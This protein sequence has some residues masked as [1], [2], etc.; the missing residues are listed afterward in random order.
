MTSQGGPSW[1][2][3]LS[4]SSQ[5]QPTQAP[6]QGSAPR[7]PAGRSD[8]DCRIAEASS[9]RHGA[10]QRQARRRTVHA[11]PKLRASQL[12]AT[13]DRLRMTTRCGVAMPTWSAS[14]CYR[15]QACCTRTRV[16]WRQLGSTHVLRREPRAGPNHPDAPRPGAADLQHAFER[17]CLQGRLDT[18]RR[19]YAMGARPVAGSV[20]GPCETLSGSGLALLFELG[21]EFTDEH[22]D[23]SR[24]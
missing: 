11:R 20:M 15:I 5:P 17:A 8:C 10:Q 3:P 12:A 4:R 16:E 22:G 24:P 1:R 2:S 23:P 9:Q 7:H 6:G 21:A 13:G 19:L 18:A 14:W